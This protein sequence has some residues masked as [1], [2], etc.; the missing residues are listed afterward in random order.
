MRIL[1]SSFPTLQGEHP[2]CIS[3]S[4]PK[5]FAIFN[6]TAPALVGR[7]I[8]KSA[9]DNCKTRPLTPVGIRSNRRGRGNVSL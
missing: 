1:C 4:T 3:C 7:T 9:L 5:T 8:S 6:L 2:G